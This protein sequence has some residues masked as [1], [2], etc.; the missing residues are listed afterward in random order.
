[1]VAKQEQRLPALLQEL[2][3]QVRVLKQ[4]VEVWALKLA[5]EL[6]QQELPV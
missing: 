6:E 1:V 5:A 3:R 2:E 4:P